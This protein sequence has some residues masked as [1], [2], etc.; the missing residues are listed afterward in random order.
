[1]TKKTGLFLFTTL[2]VFVVGAFLWWP[3]MERQF[4]GQVPAEQIQTPEFAYQNASQSDIVV[5]L[6]FPGAVTGKDFSVIGKARGPWFF[7]A[8]FPVELIDENGVQLA[9]GIAQA[10]GE[11]MT[12]EFVPFRA[13]IVV[14]NK[15]YIGPAT[16]ILHKDNPSG[17]VERD[18]SLSFPIHIEY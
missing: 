4:E 15:K 1:M 10:D 7:E 11:W 14:K 16:L 3:L 5:E 17:E 18:A 2:F 8:S 9:S 6:P 12:T 13:D